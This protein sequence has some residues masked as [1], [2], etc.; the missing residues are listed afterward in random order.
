LLLALSTTVITRWRRPWFTLSLGIVIGLMMVSYVAVPARLIGAKP[1][2]SKRDK[3]M[4]TLVGGALGVTVSM[5]RWLSAITP[6]KSPRPD[7]VRIN[8]GRGSRPKSPSVDDAWALG[9]GH[10]DP[11]VRVT[12]RRP[13][14]RS[15]RVSLRRRL[16]RDR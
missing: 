6:W 2:F 9:V 12:S 13:H 16:R 4:T 8:S 3:L 5:T 15:T 14:V 11:T 10:R 1:A 7:E